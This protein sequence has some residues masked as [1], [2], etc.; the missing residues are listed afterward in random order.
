[1]NV[2]KKQKRFYS[3]KKKRHTFKSQVVVNQVTGEIICTAHGKGKTHDFQLFKDNVIPLNQEIK[4]L[5]DKGYQ[6][7]Q[8]FIAN[9][10][11]PKKKPR[12]G[13]LSKSEKELNRELASQRIVGE[14]INRK[15][16]IFKI[17]A[18]RYRNRRKRFGLRFNLIAGL[19]NYELSLIPF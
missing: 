14:H 16:K 10:Q 13:K 15:L 19:H 17:L 1:M 2:Q 6:G 18:D 8:K 4:C 9:S 11:V 3:G 5:A 7:I 12:N